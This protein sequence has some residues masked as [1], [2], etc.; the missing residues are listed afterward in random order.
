M[1]THTQDKEFI[2]SVIGSSLLEEAIQWI[3]SNMGP[4]DVFSE[5]DLADWAESNGYETSETI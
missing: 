4:E 2:N 5:D 3:Q 1:T